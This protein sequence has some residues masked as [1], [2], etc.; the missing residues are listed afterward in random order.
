MSEKEESEE[1]KMVR[2][3]GVDGAMREDSKQ[4][5]AKNLHREA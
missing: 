5:N 3:K 4:T 1:G 2:R